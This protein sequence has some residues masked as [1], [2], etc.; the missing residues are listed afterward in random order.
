MKGQ[1]ALKI[2][3]LTAETQ[4]ELDEAVRLY[5]AVMAQNGTTIVSIKYGDPEEGKKKRVL[6]ATI[7]TYKK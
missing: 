7:T 5:I 6:F 3:V 2:K 4:E 1:L